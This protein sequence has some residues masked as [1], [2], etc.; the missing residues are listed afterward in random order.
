V[1]FYG[2]SVIATNI[3]LFAQYIFFI[4]GIVS[5]TPADVSGNAP[6]NW[7][8]AWHVWSFWQYVM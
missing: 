1:A 8:S 2:N 5:P 4:N 3:T 6:D 7:H